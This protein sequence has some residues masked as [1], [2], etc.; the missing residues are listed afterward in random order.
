MTDTTES[1]VMSDE[2]PVGAFSGDSEGAA[3]EGAAS[4]SV[5]SEGDQGSTKT[6]APEGAEGATEEP[7][8]EKR[9]ARKIA[10]L[11]R[12]ERELIKREREIRAVQE[13]LKDFQ[14]GKSLLSKDTL[15]AL[16]K[17]GI[18]PWDLAAQLAGEEPPK[19]KTPEETTSEELKALREELQSMKKA[20]QEKE[21]KSAETAVKS[22]IL[23][24]ISA[25]PE[26]FESIAIAMKHSGQEAVI[27]TMLTSAYQVYQD[28]GTMPTIQQVCEGMES[29][30]EQYY[31]EYFD[32]FKGS[33]KF[34]RYF[35]PS[36]ATEEKTEDVLEDTKQHKTLR[37]TQADSNAPRAKTQEEILAEAIA[38]LEAENRRRT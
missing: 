21:I 27:Q 5:S 1:N 17:L 2:I 36:A 38:Q 31:G 12:R 4:E 11:Q 30:F 23:S 15:A 6:P 8:E 24:T 19:P 7:L 13:E 22:S 34:S 35:S 10:D 33:K 32:S 20:E 9:Q 26:A 16:R 25:A 37:K 3:S 14:E 18:D 29:F 28:T